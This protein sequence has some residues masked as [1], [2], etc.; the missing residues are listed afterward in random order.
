M[1]RKRGTFDFII[2]LPLIGKWRLPLAMQSS[3]NFSFKR[4]KIIFD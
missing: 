1:E 2:G 4:L 3:K